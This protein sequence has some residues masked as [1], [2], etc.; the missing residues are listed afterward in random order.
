MNGWE[1]L[2]LLFGLPNGNLNDTNSFVIQFAY[3][4]TKRFDNEQM[5]DETAL[6]LNL[7]L[8]TIYSYNALNFAQSLGDPHLMSLTYTNT[9]NNFLGEDISTKILSGFNLR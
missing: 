3:E 9:L 6:S 1:I 5:T 2:F 4:L 8:A 7:Y